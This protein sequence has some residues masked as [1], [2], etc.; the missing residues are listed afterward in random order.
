MD[1]ES[2]LLLNQTRIRDDIKLS[3]IEVT[4][5]TREETK[6]DWTLNQDN[7]QKSY[8]SYSSTTSIQSLPG[9]DATENTIEEHDYYLDDEEV[10]DHE[11]EVSNAIVN[12]PQNHL[13]KITQ[14]NSATISVPNLTSNMT[15]NSLEKLFLNYGPIKKISIESSKKSRYRNANITFFEPCN[16]RSA[17]ISM[18]NTEYRHK[19][20]NIV[21]SEKK[22]KLLRDYQ[23]RM[24]ETPLENLT[25]MVQNLN[26]ESSNLLVDPETENACHDPEKETK[27]TTSMNVPT[28]SGCKRKIKSN[29]LDNSTKASKPDPIYLA[30]CLFAHWEEQLNFYEDVDRTKDHAFTMETINHLATLVDNASSHRQTE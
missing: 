27:V 19:K 15:H 5:E 3:S 20:F 21:M 13:D 28:K 25:N 29:L 10:M 30:H 14:D 11:T 16:A 17:M 8:S 24:E 4:T 23:N 9:E 12:N 2:D 18:N 6:H 1:I 26:G 7:Y 22:I